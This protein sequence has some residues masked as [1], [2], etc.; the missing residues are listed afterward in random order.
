VIKND[1]EFILMERKP[2]GYRT[3]AIMTRV[4]SLISEENHGKWFQPI[5][6]GLT[7]ASTQRHPAPYP[8]EL[9]ERL[10]RMFGF[11]G[12]TVLIRAHAAL[13]AWLQEGN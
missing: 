4:L 6:T 13:S 7:G 10:V 9:T 3:P 11:V 8:L 2:G 12:D 1:I 5:W